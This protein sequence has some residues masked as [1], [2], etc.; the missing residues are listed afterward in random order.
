[1]RLPLLFYCRLC[2][3]ALHAVEVKG[4]VVADDGNVQIERLGNQQPVE[5]VSVMLRQ[6]S[7]SKHMSNLSLEQ[8]YF[9]LQLTVFNVVEKLTGIQLAGAGLDGQL[10]RSH[11]RHQNIV[12]QIVQQIE[13]SAAE[14]GWI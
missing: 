8:E 11:Y 2:P 1:M 3:D 13:N 7:S 4:A 10:P 6:P 12:R 5:R 14:N 9:L